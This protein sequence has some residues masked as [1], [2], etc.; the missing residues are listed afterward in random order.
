[1]SRII[2]TIA[3][4]AVFASLF[5]AAHADTKTPFAGVIIVPASASPSQDDVSPSQ[6]GKTTPQFKRAQIVVFESAMAPG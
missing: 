3:A 1:M 4:A 2:K 5:T 6:A